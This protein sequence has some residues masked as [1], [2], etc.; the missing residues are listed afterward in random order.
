M[1]PDLIVIKGHAGYS[2]WPACTTR[3]DRLPKGNGFTMCKVPQLDYDNNP[4]YSTLRKLITI[5]PVV[6]FN[7]YLF[8]CFILK[9]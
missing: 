3:G 5:Y 1:K 2:S 9:V 7:F 4:I 8:C 6:F